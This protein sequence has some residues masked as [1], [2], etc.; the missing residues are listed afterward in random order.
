MERDLSL[1]EF[2]D[3]VEEIVDVDVAEVVAALFEGVVGGL[4]IAEVGDA[5]EA[6]V[7]FGCWESRKKS[8]PT[9]MVKPL[10]LLQQSVVL[11]PQHHDTSDPDKGHGN[12]FGE[13]STPEMRQMR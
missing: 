3:G 9:G 5:D 2:E 10:P 13:C 7:L 6:L 12:T 4:F 1:E 8:F 11:V